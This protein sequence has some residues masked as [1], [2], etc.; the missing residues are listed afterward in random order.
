M[1]ASETILSFY[2]PQ[3][4]RERRVPRRRR[5]SRGEG[6]L[7][8]SCAIKDAYLRNPENWGKRGGRSTHGQSDTRL[9]HIWEAMKARCGLI[10]GATPAML[11]HYRGKGIGVCPEWANSFDEFSRWA[12][13]SGYS[14]RLTIDRICGDLGYFPENCRWSTRL[15]QVR[16]RS[17]SLFVLIN[18]E[19]RPLAELA[20]ECGLEYGVLKERIK[21]GWLLE[22]ALSRPVRKRRANAVC[23]PVALE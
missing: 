8:H 15:E 18:G 3:C 20:Q 23:D 21:A 17:N 19:K 7:C 13:R 22:D 16:N 5:N 12:E 14:D 4:G 2:C 10:K 11:K 6:R 1:A 9:Y